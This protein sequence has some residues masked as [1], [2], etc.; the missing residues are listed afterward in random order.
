[1]G[2]RHTIAASLAGLLMIEAAGLAQG[3]PVVATAPLEAVVAIPRT[4]AIRVLLTHIAPGSDVRVELADGS[5]VEG[6][7]AES[8]ADA[9]VVAE[10]RFRKVV[11]LP[12]I[13]SV[14]LRVVAGMRT[15]KAFGLGAAVG[16]A[17]MIG[18]LM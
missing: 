8:S 11:V 14:R 17:I 3:P 12:D 1:M 6:I 15:A 10:G 7:V 16:G 9:L 5:R 13:V 2:V 18:M 4:Q